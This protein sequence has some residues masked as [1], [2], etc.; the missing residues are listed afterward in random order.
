MTKAQFNSILGDFRTFKRSRH[1]KS[2]TKKPTIPLIYS[3]KNQSSISYEQFRQVNRE[4]IERGGKYSQ[5]R[6]GNFLNSAKRGGGCGSCSGV[7]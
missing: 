4:K 3:K 7:R 6:W 2:V 5:G 1:V